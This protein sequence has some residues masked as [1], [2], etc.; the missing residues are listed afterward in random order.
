MNSFPTTVCRHQEDYAQIKSV[1]A[2]TS[3]YEATY[4]SALEQSIVFK[5][6]RGGGVGSGNSSSTSDKGLNGISASPEPDPVVA[7]DMEARL[8]ASAASDESSG[9]LLRS[10]KGQL[11]TQLSYPHPASS[12][13]TSEEVDEDDGRS[14]QLLRSCPFF[15]NELGGDPE[16]CVSFCS[17]TSTASTSTSFSRSTSPAHQTVPTT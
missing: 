10:G 13:L 9:S 16:W 1:S 14:N 7:S 4:K 3:S 8:D 17:T 2:V 6:L 15:H 12:S 11:K 5:K